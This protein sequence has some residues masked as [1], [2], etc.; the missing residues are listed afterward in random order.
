MT[1]WLSTLEVPAFD[2]ADGLLGEGQYALAGVRRDQTQLY[3]VRRTDESRKSVM[4]PYI[5]HAVS[6]GRRT[7]VAVIGTLVVSEWLEDDGTI[8]RE[9]DTREKLDRLRTVSNEPLPVK[10]V[11]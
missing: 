5:E 1:R 6:F 11:A 8:T 9:V 10:R 2:T 4:H 7:E 3:W